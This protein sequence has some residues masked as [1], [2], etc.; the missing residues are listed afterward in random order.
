MMPIE[1]IWLTILITTCP[2]NLILNWPS[3][4][5]KK[6]FLSWTYLDILLN[7]GF[8]AAYVFDSLYI[9]KLICYRIGYFVR[10]FIT[11]DKLQ[12]SMKFSPFHTISE[13]WFQ[14]FSNDILL[15]VLLISNFIQTLHFP[16]PKKRTVTF[17][18]E[19]RSLFILKSFLYTAI[20]FH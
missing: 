7:T 9:Q 17:L 16:F 14:V 15:N 18:F 3:L 1:L 5:Q 6:N 20:S 2:C 13:L 11:T 8:N 19:H 10:N 12:M 4:K